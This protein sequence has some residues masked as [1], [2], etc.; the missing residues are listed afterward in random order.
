MNL[1]E[2]IDTAIK[3]NIASPKAIRYMIV[4]IVVIFYSFQKEVVYLKQIL[5]Q[6]FV[7]IIT[8]VLVFAISIPCFR[9][10]TI[11]LL[12]LGPTKLQKIKHE[13]AAIHA[14]NQRISNV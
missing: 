14:V 8:F 11:R 4:F 12:N 2:I 7:I 5:K 10:C 13:K 6:T 3:N 1:I 9:A